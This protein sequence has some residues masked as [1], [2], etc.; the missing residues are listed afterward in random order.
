M[1]HILLIS[2]LVFIKNANK[3]ENHSDASVSFI[4]IESLVIGC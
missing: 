1:T 3:N 2:E 4:D